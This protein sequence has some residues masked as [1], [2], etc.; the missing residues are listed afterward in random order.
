M[1]EEKQYKLKYATSIASW[2][3]MNTFKRIEL[4]PVA[5]VLKEI[6]IASKRPKLVN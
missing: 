3:H 4:V 2:D 6:E 5:Q 1:E